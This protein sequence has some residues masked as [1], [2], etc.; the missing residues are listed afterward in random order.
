MNPT[1]ASQL[2]RAIA[3]GA[4]KGIF[5]LPKGKRHFL[6]KV[7]SNTNVLLLGASGKVKL[8][9]K[10]RGDATKEVRLIFFNTKFVQYLSDFLI[11][12]QQARP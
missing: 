8:A 11:I 4:E 12:E 1:A 10:A 2:N 7:C 9:A 6:Q 3:H 5:V